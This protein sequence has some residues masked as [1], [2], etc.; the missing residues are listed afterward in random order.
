MNKI[1]IGAVRWALIT[2]LAACAAP[3]VT[4]PTTG[5]PMADAAFPPLGATWDVRITNLND[6]S[7][8]EETRSVTSADYK[9]GKYPAVSSGNQILVFDPATRNQVA[10]LRNGMEESTWS[11]D[12]GQ[13]SWPLFVGKTWSPEYTEIESVA[14]RRFT[15]VRP[16]RRVEA[17]ED[18]TVPAGTFKAFRIQTL[19]GVSYFNSI[20][21]WYSP[22]VGIVVKTIY[23]GNNLNGIS[24]T[25]TELLSRPK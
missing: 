6:G 20:T 17:F 22:E 21:N 24:N 3:T 4:Q 16:Q 2:T 25:Q 15:N 19:P 18:V 5:S 1:A 23:H 9:G 14:Q 12:G 7:S 11:P 8:Y 10:T 13:F